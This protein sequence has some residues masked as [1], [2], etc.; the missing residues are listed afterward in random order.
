MNELNSP[1]ELVPQ[2]NIWENCSRSYARCFLVAFFFYFMYEW[3]HLK[4]TLT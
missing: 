2:T 3:S 1:N 4:N